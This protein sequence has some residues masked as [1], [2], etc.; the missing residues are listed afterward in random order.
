MHGIQVFTFCLVWWMYL[1]GQCSVWLGRSWQWS[2]YDEELHHV[3]VIEMSGW[4][5]GPIACARRPWWLSSYWILARRPIFK[6]KAAAEENLESAKTR[7]YQ[8][9]RSARWI[10]CQYAAQRFRHLSG[11]LRSMTNSWTRHTTFLVIPSNLIDGSQTFDP[12]SV[13]SRVLRLWVE[14]NCSGRANYS[15]RSSVNNAKDTS[16]VVRNSPLPALKGGST[17][18]PEFRR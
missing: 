2:I 9:W 10:H 1:N 13:L 4:L 14:I 15:I 18:V 12:C 3:I 16:R 17:F 11:G 6:G 7:G 5:C 8:G